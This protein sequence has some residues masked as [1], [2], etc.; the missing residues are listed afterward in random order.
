MPSQGT[1]HNSPSGQTRPSG[2]VPPSGTPMKVRW[3]TAVTKAMAATA[4]GV[5]GH[6]V[7]QRCRGPSG[8][9]PLQR[10]AAKGFQEGVCAP[11][12]LANCQNP[13]GPARPLKTARSRFFG[14][15]GT[16]RPQRG[17]RGNSWLAQC[18]SKHCQILRFPLRLAKLP[19]TFAGPMM[20]PLNTIF[21]ERSC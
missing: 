14:K 6:G 18:A 17:R 21:H 4:R 11:L 3:K 16:P 5:E 2:A 12:F 13:N 10:A 9:P 7:P 15:A 8:A 20:R 19:H 1:T